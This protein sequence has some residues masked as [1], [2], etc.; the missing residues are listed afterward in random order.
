MWGLSACNPPSFCFEYSVQLEAHLTD[1]DLNPYEFHGDK[2]LDGRY[3]LF[4]AL[5]WEWLEHE[6]CNYIAHL[7]SPHKAEVLR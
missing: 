6:E 4:L 2:Q 5:L 1:N 7:E 3:K